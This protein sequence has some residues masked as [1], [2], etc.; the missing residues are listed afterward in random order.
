MPL[1][2]FPRLLRDW[3]PPERF[4]QMSGVPDSPR[5]HAALNCMGSLTR[6]LEEQTGQTVRIRLE[7]QG[8]I[9]ASEEDSI[10]WDSE[11]ALPPD[12]T[13]LSRNAWLILAGRERLFAHSQVVMVALP[14][15]AREAVERGEEPLGSLFLER[16]GCVERSGL[17]LARAYVP[18]LAHRLG[19]ET[20]TLYWCRRSLFCVNHV[21]RARILEIFLPSLM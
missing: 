10:L 1:P 13:I 9:L 3:L 15:E 4:F 6:H 12:G 16:E 2:F 19:Q 14:M 20:D 7:S 17:E 18:D 8:P 11:H 5:L 21:T